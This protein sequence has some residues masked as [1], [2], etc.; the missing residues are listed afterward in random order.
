MPACSIRC[1]EAHPSEHEEQAWDEDQLVRERL[2]LL[3][4]P[5]QALFKQAGIDA[6]HVH[7]RND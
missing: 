7:P 4:G 5:L 2:I 1:H 3:H 6:Y